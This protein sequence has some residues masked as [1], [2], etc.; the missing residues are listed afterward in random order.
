MATTTNAHLFKLLQL[1][2]VSLP[3]GGYSFSQGMEWACE[4]AWI[5]NVQET[6]TWL[7]SQIFHSLAPVDLALVFH[8][9][10]AVKQGSDALTELNDLSLACRETQEL[11]MMEVAMGKALHRWANNLDLAIQWQV[12]EPS[13]VVLF[14]VISSHWGI[15]ADQTA[16]GFAWSWLENQV[17]AATKLVPLGQTQAQQL[18]VALQPELSTAVS[19][20]KQINLE[21]IGAGLP[22]LA[23]ASAKHETQYSRLFRS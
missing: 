22:G 14:S 2:S 8:S 23:I 6:Q 21:Q 15:D 12:E 20:A 9:H 13:F 3:V 10:R 19:R 7:T 18:L 4:E 1:S 11:R 17:Q 16:S 5:T